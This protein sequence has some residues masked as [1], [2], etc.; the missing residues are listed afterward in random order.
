[1]SIYI[2]G[3]DFM[4]DITDFSAAVAVIGPKTGKGST[5]VRLKGGGHLTIKLPFMEFLAHVDNGFKQ[6]H[7][8]QRAEDESA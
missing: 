4:L 6:Q 8:Q 7:Q 2:N 3:A 1:M 5:S